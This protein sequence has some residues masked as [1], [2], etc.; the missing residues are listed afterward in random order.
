MVASGTAV[1]FGCSR[2]CHQ[3]APESL[4]S[5]P[6]NARPNQK[7]KGLKPLLDQSYKFD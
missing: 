3:L 6:L 1:R 5:K 2:A 7:Q 4:R